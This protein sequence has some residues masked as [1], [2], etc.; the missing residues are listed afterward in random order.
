MLSMYPCPLASIAGSAALALYTCAMT[1]ISQI[2]CQSSFGVSGPTPTPIPALLQ[3]KSICPC[4]DSVVWI[5]LMTSDSLETSVVIAVAPI[6]L[7]TSS[8]TSPLMSAMTTCAAPSAI[9]RLA[10]AFPIPLAPPVTTIFLPS[11]FIMCS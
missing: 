3:S 4:F 11:R 10:M 5:R 7:A 9:N 2:R 6:S 8:S 1:L